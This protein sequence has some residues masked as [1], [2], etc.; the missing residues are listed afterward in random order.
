LQIHS[1]HIL[2]QMLPILEALEGEMLDFGWV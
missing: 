1:D 2:N